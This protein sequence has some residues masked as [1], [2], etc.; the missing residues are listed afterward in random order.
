MEIEREMGAVNGNVVFQRKFYLPIKRVCHRANAGPE[1]PVMNNEQICSAFCRSLQR[2]GGSIDSGRD[3][4][5]PAGVLKLQSVERV[6][7]ILNLRNAQVRIA[8]LDNLLHRTHAM[9]LP[10]RC[11][12]GSDFA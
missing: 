6:Y 12:F 8:V 11:N 4:C 9:T 10:S 1:H 3:F 2:T 5:E 7:V